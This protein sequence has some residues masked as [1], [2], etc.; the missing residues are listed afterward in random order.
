MLKKLKNIQSTG[1]FRLKTRN[2]KDYEDRILTEDY[3]L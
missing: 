1:R 3:H 2:T